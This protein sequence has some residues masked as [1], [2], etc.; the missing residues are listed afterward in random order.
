MDVVFIDTPCTTYPEI[1][2]VLFEML[3]PQTSPGHPVGTILPSPRIEV[4]LALDPHQSD[5]S[6]VCSHNLIDR[7]F[8]SGKSAIEP[9]E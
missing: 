1:A 9:V 2:T 4:S 6:A 3:Y 7:R 8:S 5:Q